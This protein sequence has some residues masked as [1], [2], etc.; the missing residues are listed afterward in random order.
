M[1]AIKN[2]PDNYNLLSPAGFK[3]QIKNLPTVTY[4]CQSVN[5]PGISLGEALRTTPFIDFSVPG[6]KVSYDDLS[7]SF[8]VDEDLTN[9]LEVL[10]WMKKL[11]SPTDP[12]KEY[13]SLLNDKS[14]N[15]MGGIYSDCSLTVLTN[16]MNANLD[17]SFVDCW[18]TGL[19][20]LS[21]DTM[22]DDITPI[23]ASATFK[24]RDFT[25]KKVT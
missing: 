18:P 11:G 13:S 19:S 3:F 23:T 10:N 2:L 12:S 6:D 14:A 20:E 17:I 24:F 9:F 25:I 21:L 5:L 7:V 4:F 8:L 22:T 1:S 15:A 16:N